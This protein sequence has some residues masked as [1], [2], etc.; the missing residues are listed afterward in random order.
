ME[1]PDEFHTFWSA[2]VIPGKPCTVEV[3]SDTDCSLTNVAIDR[4][5]AREGRVILGVSVNGGPQVAV[6]PFTIGTFE[7]TGVD[8]KFS[9]GDTVVF[10]T[11]GTAVP[12]HICGYLAGGFFV[13]IDNGAPPPPPRQEPEVTVAVDGEPVTPAP[14]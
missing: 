7:S 9:R 12:V 2:V 1:L 3:P 6:A 10:T 5:E 14:V 8:I 11:T 4:G 13:S